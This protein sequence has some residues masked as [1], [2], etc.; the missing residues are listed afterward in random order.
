MILTLRKGQGTTKV[1]LAFFVYGV[2]IVI[3]K[4]YYKRWIL[5][6]LLS[7]RGKAHLHADFIYCHYLR[8]N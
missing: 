6:K 3:M 5:I 7:L 2:I 8:K 4:A 1:P